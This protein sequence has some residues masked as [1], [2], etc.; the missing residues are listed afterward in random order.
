MHVIYGF[1]FFAR[2]DHRKCS[3]IQGHV[4]KLT[5]LMYKELVLL[6]P[7]P[8]THGSNRGGPRLSTRPSSC[9]LL[10]FCPYLYLH[11]SFYCLYSLH[12]NSAVPLLSTDFAT[13]NLLY[14][15][16]LRT[17]IA[18]TGQPFE[19]LTRISA[20]LQ[21]APPRFSSSFRWEF[22][23]S[24]RWNLDLW[25]IQRIFSMHVYAHQGFLLWSRDI[26]VPQ[27]AKTS[28]CKW[29]RGAHE[30]AVVNT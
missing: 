25:N 13:W 29:S 2:R 9:G 4:T 12:K 27:L 24:L 18:A 1:S 28:F 5:E 30:F 26:F 19:K 23:P 3:I 10:S 14:N 22:A 11:F 20:L 21:R 15:G 6:H 16:V 7:L 17:I 8:L